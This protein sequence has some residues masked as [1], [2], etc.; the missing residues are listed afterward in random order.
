MSGH[1]P[2]SGT[3]RVR[4][5]L[6]HL[7]TALSPFVEGWMKKKHGADWR[8]LAS[9][10]GGGDPDGML[11]AYGLLKTIIDNWRYTFEEAFQQRER[12]RL[13]GRGGQH[14]GPGVGR[15]PSPLACAPVTAA[16]ACRYIAPCTGASSPS[17]F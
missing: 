12:H 1:H 14:V 2:K 5:A 9:R 10:A 6:D 7:P 13:V 3:Q 11:D 4:D 16:V 8:K 17:P 15:W